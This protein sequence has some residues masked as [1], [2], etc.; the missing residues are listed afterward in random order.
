MAI[1][2][3]N[4]PKTILKDGKP[5]QYKRG[6][7]KKSSSRNTYSNQAVEAAENMRNRGVTG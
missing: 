4:E 3:G 7:P 1:A 2:T 5:Y 6:K